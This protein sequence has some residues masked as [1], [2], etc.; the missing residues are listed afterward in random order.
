MSI[1]THFPNVQYTLYSNTTQMRPDR[2]THTQINREIDGT[3]ETFSV[4]L[5]YGRITE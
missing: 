1:I 5:F 4:T 3:P 2:H